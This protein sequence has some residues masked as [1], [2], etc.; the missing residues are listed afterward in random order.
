MHGLFQF[1]YIHAV[2]FY[3]NFA[4]SYD[5]NLL[6]KLK[7]KKTSHLNNSSYTNML[8]LGVFS[9]QGKIKK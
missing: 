9:L 1:C 3:F 4:V 5:I 2:C 8:L 6:F 7:I